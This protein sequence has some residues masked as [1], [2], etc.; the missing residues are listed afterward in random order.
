MNGKLFV[1]WGEADITPDGQA[2]E[3]SGQYYQRV[4]TGIHSRLK[5][6]VMLLEQDGEASALIAVDVVGIPADFAKLIQQNAAAQIPELTAERVIVNAIHTHNAPPLFA[7][8]KWWMPEPGAIS[9]EEYRKFLSDRITQALSE[10]YAN[11]CASGIASVLDYARAGHCRR[12]VYQDDSAEMYGDTSRDDFIGMEGNEDSGVDIMFFAD[13]NRKPTGVI[14]NL[15]C[16]SQVMEATYQISSDFMGKLRENL[17]QEFGPEFK[18]LPQIS[19]AGC[20]APRDLTRNYRGEP[21]FWREAGVD[22][23]GERLTAAVC[24]GGQKTADRFDYAPEFKHFSRNLA[25]PLRR[26]TEEEYITAKREIAELEA[27]QS[28]EAAY[29]EFCDEVHVNEQIPNRPGPYDDKKRHFVEIRNRE[30]VV[31]RYE[32]QGA[33]PE[34]S[35]D[36]Q[37]LRLGEAVFA[38]NPFELF[39]E[40]GQRIKARSRAGQTFLIQLANGYE[41]YL[42]SKYAEQL[43][44]YGALIINGKIGSDGGT[45]LVNETLKDIDKLWD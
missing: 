16:P 11:R 7:I 12:A 17:K 38:I 1:G 19:A 6:T 26:A 33:T 40:F 23:I 13:E 39:L 15:A 37:V 4:A 34:L 28:S 24:R 9:A 41:G 8:R 29:Q 42:P 31:R 2:V 25:L 44:G 36:L 45:V 5:T 14:V 35:I 20:Q 27:E 18:L 22:E 43:G 32:E 3:L 10:A 21:D 30:A